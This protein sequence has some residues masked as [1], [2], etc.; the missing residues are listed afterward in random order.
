[1]CGAV[2]ALA[3]CTF[4]LK[5]NPIDNHS[6]ISSKKLQ[7]Q[8]FKPLGHY[9]FMQCGNSHLQKIQ[10]NILSH[11]ILATYKKFTV[12]TIRF[13]QN[14]SCNIYIHPIYQQVAHVTVI[15]HQ[16]KATE[17][18]GYMSKYLHKSPLSHI[19]TNHSLRY[20]HSV[21]IW[22]C[23]SNSDLAITWFGAMPPIVCSPRC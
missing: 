22:L 10:E 7:K 23:T 6:N 16:T 12:A 9:T 5:S 2:R 13:T 1:M 8:N 15:I 19:C 18:I 21:N 11:I 3:T 17:Y 4:I 20:I 14:V